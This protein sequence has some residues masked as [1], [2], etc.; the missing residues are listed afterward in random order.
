MHCQQYYNLIKLLNISQNAGWVF[1]VTSSLSSMH[2][3]FKAPVMEDATTRNL[4]KQAGS[5][6]IKGTYRVWTT[7]SWCLKLLW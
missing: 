4:S 5:Y 3:S 1:F 7:F 6:L 2:S